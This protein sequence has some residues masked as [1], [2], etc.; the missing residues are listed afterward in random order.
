MGVLCG[1]TTASPRP[2]IFHGGGSVY[3]A[4]ASSLDR[5]TR[6]DRYPSSAKVPTTVLVLEDDP[7]IREIISTLLEEEGFEV[8]CAGNLSEAHALIERQ[9]FTVALVDLRLSDG[10]GLDFVRMLADSPATAV[11]VV[12]G[13]GSSM[14]RVV[15]IELGADDYIVKPF[16]AREFV[17]RV[18][19]HARRIGSLMASVVEAPSAYEVAGWTVDILGRSVTRQADKASPYLSEPEFRTLQVLLERR[20]QVL[21]RDDI[22]TFVVGSGERDPLDRR[23]DVHVSSIRRKLRSDNEPVIRT[24]HR[25]GYVID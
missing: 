4:D 17:A 2:Q 9:S 20:G 23:V 13:R 1:L 18:K 5:A 22:Y 24:V 16:E 11:I 12:S 10:D 15:G 7:S 6:Q 14:D 8:S 21:S 19:R 25:V 3:S